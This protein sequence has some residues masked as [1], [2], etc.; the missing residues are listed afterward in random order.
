MRCRV[1]QSLEI[2]LWL[3]PKGF[4][5]KSLFNLSIKEKH[6]TFQYLSI[7]FVKKKNASD[8]HFLRN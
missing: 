5:N 8:V 6:F 2:F 1:L 7:Y 3:R 4:Q